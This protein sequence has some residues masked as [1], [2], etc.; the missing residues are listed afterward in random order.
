MIP[1]SFTQRGLWFI[2]KLE[3]PS[4]TYNLLIILRLSGDLDSGALRAALNDVVDRH[5]A[6]RTVFREQDGEPHQHIVTR[7]DLGDLLEVTQTTESDLADALAAAARIG[8]DLAAAPPVRTWLFQLG[9]TE[10]V[11]MLLMHHII[12][13]EWSMG[14]L[15]RDFAAAYTARYAGH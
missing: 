12:T 14:P 10:H 6:L 4:P 2:H 11:L 8:F 9:P 3:G 1:L 15:T 5:E 13:D 7:A